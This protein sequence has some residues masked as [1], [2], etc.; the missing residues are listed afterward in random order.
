MAYTDQE[1]IGKPPKPKSLLDASLLRP[2]LG[3]AQPE[4]CLQLAVDLLHRP[5]SLVRTYYLSRN[6]L[7]QLG[8]Q[9]FRL[10]GGEVPPSL[11]QHHGDVTDV[12]PTQARAIHPAGFAA[13][14][15]ESRDTRVR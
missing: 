5:P 12:P 8:P 9:D 14:S 2:D 7:V 4:V 3:L 10:L 6:P 11:T 1:Q 13:V 15:P